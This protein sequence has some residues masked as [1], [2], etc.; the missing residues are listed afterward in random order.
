MESGSPPAASPAYLQPTRKDR[1]VT[2]LS[3]LAR[4]RAQSNGYSGTQ[5]WPARAARDEGATRAV[6]PQALVGTPRS[7][8]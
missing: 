2:L 8:G 1:Q 4:R 3:N 7:I 5:S 6:I